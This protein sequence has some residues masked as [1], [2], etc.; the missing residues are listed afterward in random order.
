MLVTGLGDDRFGRAM[1]EP[2]TTM[3]PVGAL[4]VSGSAAEVAVLPL[5]ASTGAA[6][7][8]NA[9]V[10]TVN[11]ETDAERTSN[12]RAVYGDFIWAPKIGNGAMHLTDP[13]DWKCVAVA[14]E[15]F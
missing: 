1:R 7:W 10:P 11:A 2:V 4:S 6:A 13:R 5:C 15:C 12:T 8:A 3:S 9:D 14:S